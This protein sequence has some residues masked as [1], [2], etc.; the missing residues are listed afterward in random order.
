MGKRSSAQ[1]DHEDEWD[2]ELDK[3][4][5]STST[6]SAHKRARHGDAV[7]ETP[8][9]A[10]IQRFMGVDASSAAGNSNSEYC[11]AVVSVLLLTA[12]AP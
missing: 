4:A 1:S 10:L 7:P 2:E 12:P 6:E 9:E 11:N 3:V 5:A 8:Q